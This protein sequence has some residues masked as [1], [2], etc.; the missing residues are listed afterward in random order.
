MKNK[1]AVFGIGLLIL[2]ML[3]FIST[4]RPVSSAPGSIAFRIS[5]GEGFRHIAARLEY[6]KLIRSRISFIIYGF[7]SG[8][9]RN[10]K[11]G[12]YQL[13]PGLN[14]GEI[15]DILFRGQTDTTITIIEG[16]TAR[17]I[18]RRLAETGLVS[19]GEF[20]EIAA[21]FE[22]MLFPDTYRFSPKFRPVDILLRMLETFHLKAG[23]LLPDLDA[24]VEEHIQC[25]KKYMGETNPNSRAVLLKKCVNTDDFSG[26]AYNKLIVASLVEREVLT[27]ADR[28]IIAGI[29][30]RR[31][32]IGMPIQI[33]ATVAYSVC[34]KAFYKCRPPVKS[35]FQIDSPYNTYR[36]SGLTP[37]PIANP[38]RA[39]IESAIYPQ[40]SK[41]LYYLSDPGSKRTIFSVTLE[42]HNK[43]RALY[44]NL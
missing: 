18:D 4:L 11:P 5:P 8:A 10:L 9:G 32:A 31:L 34:G 22:G 44:L 19:A 39:A 6:E 21:P 37:T 42:E 2:T 28:K 38:G 30:Y 24:K 26:R 15:Y 20:S 29:I 12:L 14:V 7:I 3:V 35:D 13:K 27:N 43:N 36:H 16:E 41:Y 25:L 17:D 40:P 33:D 23:D 1:I